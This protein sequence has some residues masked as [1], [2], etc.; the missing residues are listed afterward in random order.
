[1]TQ[2]VSVLT[3]EEVNDLRDLIY[4]KGVAGL[5]GAFPSRGEVSI[6]SALTTQRGTAH[7]P[8]KPRPVLVLGVDAPGVI[9]AERHDLAVTRNFWDTISDSLRAHL[10]CPIADELRPITQKHTTED[11]VMGEA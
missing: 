3:A 5:K 9:K 1:M 7:A 8:Q 2:V 11:L 4:A 6:R 10:D